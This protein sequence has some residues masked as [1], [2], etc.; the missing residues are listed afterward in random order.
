[1]EQGVEIGVAELDGG[2]REQDDGLG[3]VA[4]PADRPVGP[5]LGVADVVG[6]VDDDQIEGG[7]RVQAKQ[8]APG[9]PPLGVA[10]EQGLVQQRIGQDGAGVFLRP[11]AVQ[12]GLFDA[13]AQGRAVQVVEALVEAFHLFEPFALGDQG[14][15]ADDQH[16]PQFA[17]GLKLLEDQPGLDG[18]ADAD[19]IGD[20][21]PRPVG[22]DELEHGPELVGDELDARWA[23]ASSSQFLAVGGKESVACT[24]AASVVPAL[25][26]VIADLPQS[27]N[28]EGIEQGLV[29]DQGQPFDLRLG[30]QHP[31]KRV[32]VC[33]GHQAGPAGVVECPTGRW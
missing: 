21:Q 28:A 13:V 31:V 27:R 30:N 32:A 24:L 29:A 1:M 23:W 33:T 10:H 25:R 5:G 2:G 26:P 20:E 7:R 19:L 4:E 11:D 17:A 9:A 3:V 12:V 16:G 18:L 6:L 8:S 22:L 14:L 15:G